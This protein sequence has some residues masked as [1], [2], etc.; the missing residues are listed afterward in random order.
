MTL[1]NLMIF[2]YMA[3]VF[4]IGIK[5]SL[6]IS[7]ISDFVLADRKLSGP[8]AALGAGASDMSGW[9]LMA[10][11]GYLFIFGLNRIWMP[12]SLLIGA[13]LNWQI[14]AKK[15]RVYTEVAGD[16]LTIP[17]YFSNR[18]SQNSDQIRLVTS[19]VIIIFFTAYASANFVMCAKLTEQLF[20]ISYTKSLIIS[21][22]IMSS[23]TCLG[24]F[25]AVNWVDFFQGS[26][27]LIALIIVPVVVVYHLGGLGITFEQLSLIPGYWSLSLEPTKFINDFGWGLGYFGQVHILARFMAIRNHEAIPTAKYICMIWMLFSLVGAICCGLVGRAHYHSLDDP[28]MVFI[29]L[30]LELFDPWIAAILISAVLSA[31]MS[32][33]TAQILNAASSLV[34]DFY[35]KKLRK[36]ASQRELLWIARVCVIIIALIAMRFALDPKGTILALVGFAWA[37]MG[38]SFGPVILVSLY[39]KKI[40]SKAAIFGMILGTSCVLIW[41]YLEDTHYIFQINGI[42]PGFIL[43][44][45]T[46]FLVSK[47]DK[48]LDQGMIEDFD[49]TNDILAR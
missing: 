48:S 44:L 40:T 36:R 13:Y 15:L 47:L 11:P 46:I 14:V 26:L 41:S 37:G 30:A 27:M 1:F 45:L 29:N 5:A 9:L 7:K 3:I 28:E 39:W 34:E 21:A 18:F 35:H 20:S 32:T 31:I 22:I 4:A 38:A 25:L 19:L 43:N 23:Y 6:K 12:L 24:G 10:V 16:S 8:I 17:S 33:I 2:I 42:V 49:T